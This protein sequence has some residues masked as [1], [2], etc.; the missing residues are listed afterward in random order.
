MFIVCKDRCYML[1]TA[2][3]ALEHMASENVEEHYNGWK[4]IVKRI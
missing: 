3:K 4:P 1:L 2:F